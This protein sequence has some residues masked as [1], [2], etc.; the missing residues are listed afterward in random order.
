MRDLAL[1]WPQIVQQAAA[2][3]PWGH[4]MVLLDKLDDQAVRDWYAAEAVR[5]GWTRDVLG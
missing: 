4:L 2:Q 3:L 1:A 5:H